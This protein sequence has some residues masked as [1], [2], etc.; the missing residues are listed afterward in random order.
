[1]AGQNN[2]GGLTH[3]R[4]AYS[5][6]NRRKELQ[7]RSCRTGCLALPEC[8]L[9][10]LQRGL[11]RSVRQHGKPARSACDPM[12]AGRALRKGSMTDSGAVRPASRRDWLSAYGSLRAMRR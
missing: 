3:R 6:W 10:L 4:S 11:A 2:I 7:D 1:L 9:S 5:D 8:Q 12:V